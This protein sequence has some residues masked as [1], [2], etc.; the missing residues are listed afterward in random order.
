MDERPGFP[1]A[2]RFFLLPGG[3]SGIASGLDQ[4]SM[5]ACFARPETTATL[6]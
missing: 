5:R 1:Y 4:R 6:E 3:R 2:F